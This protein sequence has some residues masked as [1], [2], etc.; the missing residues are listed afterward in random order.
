MKKKQGFTLIELLGVIILIG[1]I[2]LI[3]IPS[4]TTLIK[5][6]KERLYDSQVLIIE[7]KAKDWSIE[8]VDKLS[9][10]RCTCLSLEELISSGY[11]EQSEIVDPRN[12]NNKMNGCISIGY[13]S[14]YSKYEY[15]YVEKSCEQCYI[16]SA[17]TFN[18]NFGGTGEEY[19]NG[20]ISVT[21]GY[22]VSGYTD[23][24]D[25]DLKGINNGTNAGTVVKYDLNGKILWKKAFGGSDSEYLSSISATNDGF[26]VVGATNSE[27]GDLSG[28]NITD[29]PFGGNA[30]IV[31]YDT[32]GNIVWVTTIGGSKYDIFNYVTPID[33]GYIAVGRSYSPELIGVG[34]RSDDAIIVKFDLNGNLLWTRTFGGSKSD[35]F[36]SVAS[37]SDGYIAVGR[38][39]SSDFDMSSLTKGGTDGIIIKYDTNGNVVWKKTFGGSA[40]DALHGILFTN[41]SYIVV[42]YSRSNDN[43]LVGLINKGNSDAVIIKYDLN[44]NIVWKNSFGGTGY[45]FLYDVLTTNDGYIT[46]GG[47]S[48]SDG[49]LTGLNRGSDDATIVKFDFDGNL[50]WNKNYGGSKYE[51]FES[52]AIA[53]DGYIA[54]G[55]SDSTDFDLT[56]LYKGKYYDSI[57]V[58]Y[59]SNGEILQKCP[60][61]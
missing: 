57:I 12:S 41:D 6:S 2:G 51:D 24:A 30:V 4:I 58:K 27:D 8:N 11:I 9:E 44:N 56:G 22:I 35:S 49:D 34:T 36:R 17:I 21:D 7:S 31:K 54:V 16:N 26:V 50:L 52:L 42:G 37:V 25:G 15:N 59:N 43:D 14:I 28:V 13:N 19:F 18:K 46:I 10:T 60:L 1:I 61:E 29:G 33:D 48:S 53:S 5:N 45:E 39:E 32:N 40:N 3:A 47:S 55:Y 23:S 20:I 38:S